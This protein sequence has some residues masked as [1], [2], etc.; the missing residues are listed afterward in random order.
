MVSSVGR[1]KT[2]P[3]FT[4]WTW[5]HARVRPFSIWGEWQ[6][7]TEWSGEKVRTNLDSI[8]VRRALGGVDELVG[9]AFCDRLDVAERG[10]ASL[11]RKSDYTRQK[12][13]MAYTDGEKGDGLVHSPQRGHIDSLATDGSL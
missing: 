3:F 1:D 10:L 2:F 7:W 6:S 8:R 12:G 11:G 9:E 4:G 13:G 5:R